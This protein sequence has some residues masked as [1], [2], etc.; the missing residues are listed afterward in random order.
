MEENNLT[1]RQARESA[2]LAAFSLTFHPD[3][4]QQA[5][6]DC[7]ELPELE[8]DAFTARLLRDLTAHIDDIDGE[9]TAHLKGWSL[10]RLP[11]V[12]LTAMR[13]A[14]AEMLY[15]D[16]KKPA[17]AINEAKAITSLST[18]CWAPSPGSAAWPMPTRSRR[19][20][21]PWAGHKQLRNLSGC[22]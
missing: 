9:I 18:A 20:A 15:G 3:E 16:E 14:L 22:V 11:R 21:D 13:V 8:Q 7:G 12:S 17:V 4:P 19:H 10:G 2:F 1:R 5:L 6:R